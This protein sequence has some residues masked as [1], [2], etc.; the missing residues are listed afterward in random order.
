MGTIAV[1]GASGNIGSRV[2]AGLAS[3][4]RP[5]RA[6]TRTPIAGHDGVEVHAADLTNI[7]DAVAAL[8]GVSAVY[9]TPPEGGDDPT[10][11]ELAVCNNVI[12]AAAKHAV[13]HVVMHTAVRADRGDTGARVLD[14]KTTIERALADSGLG[15]TI[16][17]P[18]WFMQNLWAAR[19]YL[20]NGVVS[21]PWPG[22]MVWAA[23]D[24]NDIVDAAIRFLDQ[25]PANRSFD[26]HVPGG[27]TG[28]QIATAASTVLGH[29][30]TYQP[31][32]VS[33][34]DYV[35]TFP[36]S[37][38]HREMY[39]E[40]FDYFISTTYLGDPQ[41]ITEALPGFRIRGL[42]DF[43]RHELFTDN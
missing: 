25:G 28:H 7:D 8:E 40:L 15:Y 19:D 42:E 16:L 41:P 6:I 4:G 31:A 22:D 35:G 37:E 2:V 43:L 1:I 5:V 20:Q 38:P 17:R 13:E 10:G 32:G 12:E 14:N 33:T 36:F 39:V 24:I 11:L 29:E 9:L 3:G 30:V 26:I 18:A 21:L 27:I 23:T 34:R